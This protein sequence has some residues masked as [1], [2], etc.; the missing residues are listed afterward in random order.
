MYRVVCSPC[1]RQRPR[2]RRT[3]CKIAL[4]RDYILLV[5]RGRARTQKTT[6]RAHA[7]QRIKSRARA[8]LHS[9]RFFRSLPRA[10]AVDRQAARAASRSADSIK[11]RARAT[12]RA[13]RVSSQR[14]L[15][16]LPVLSSDDL[17]ETC[18]DIQ[19]RNLLYR[20]KLKHSF[21]NNVKMRDVIV[22]SIFIFLF[23]KSAHF[24]A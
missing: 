11:A 18:F 23:S 20:A 1:G 2:L 6:Q 10:A 8:R 15:L 5:S 12:A 16:H 17:L 9:S 24:Y 21:I 14:R 13:L 4:L 19:F 3:L 22:R 7:K